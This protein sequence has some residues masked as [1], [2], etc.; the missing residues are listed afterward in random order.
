MELKRVD[1]WGKRKT[2]VVEGD[3]VKPKLVPKPIGQSVVRKVPVAKVPVGKP[4]KMAA[5]NPAL[6]TELRFRDITV[7]TQ[8]CPRAIH[9]RRH[10]GDDGKC[11]CGAGTM[12]RKWSR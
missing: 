4:V 10:W 6:R 3:K 12:G 5:F 1:K 2:E 7:D 9:T 11:K 8:N